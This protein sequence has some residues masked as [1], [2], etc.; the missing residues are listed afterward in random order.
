MRVRI[1]T[2]LASGKLCR[3][4]LLGVVTIAMVIPGSD[5]ALVKLAPRRQIILP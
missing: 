4:F 3:A 2:G 1:R 5:G